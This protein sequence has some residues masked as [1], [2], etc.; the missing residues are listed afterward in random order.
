MAHATMTQPIAF[1]AQ[2]LPSAQG[3]KRYVGN[4]IMI[5]TD[6]NLKSWR[7]VVAAAC[8]LEAPLSCGV[9][10]VVEFRY[11]RPKSHYGTRKGQ[12]YLKGNAPIFKTSAPD[13]DKLIR[14]IGDALTGV[15]F[16]DDALVVHITASKVYTTHTVGAHITLTPLSE[17]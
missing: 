4:G 13:C 8:P 6:K 7:S 15:A 12:P 16:V 17:P 2:G 11:S 3:S 9:A 5:D 14:A 1:F 10:M